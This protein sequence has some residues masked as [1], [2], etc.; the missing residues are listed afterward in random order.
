MA[1]RLL[2]PQRW[3]EMNMCG[4]CDGG[5]AGWERVGEASPMFEPTNAFVAPTGKV[6]GSETPFPS[7][8]AGPEPSSTSVAAA[9]V[10]SPKTVPPANV[11][12]GGSSPAQP[13]APT[14]GPT[15]DL[16]QYPTLAGAPLSPAQFY[17]AALMPLTDEQLPP[18]PNQTPHQ[19]R[20]SRQATAA[21]DGAAPTMCNGA[22]AAAHTNDT[23]A[24]LDDGGTGAVG[25]GPA[26]DF[27][28]SSD[29]VEAHD[30]PTTPPRT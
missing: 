30:R 29:V 6:S 23:P 21:D 9:A 19:D 8:T 16:V 4:C 15:R 24:P 7:P 3:L 10:V 18:Y 5:S 14:P 17:A 28:D 27:D 12:F 26:D 25:A 22:N 20:A 2:T 1:K 11:S 13:A